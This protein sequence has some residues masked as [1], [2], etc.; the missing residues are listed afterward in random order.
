GSNWASLMVSDPRSLSDG[1]RIVLAVF[2]SRPPGGVPSGPLALRFLRREFVNQLSTGKTSLALWR[3]CSA[4]RKSLTD[5][6]LTQP[7]T[8]ILLGGSIRIWVA[9][10]QLN[11]R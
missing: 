2:E 8:L 9:V 6:K 11:G 7:L 3:H 5:E 1:L 10:K 4:R